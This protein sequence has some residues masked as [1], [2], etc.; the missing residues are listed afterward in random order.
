MLLLSMFGLKH[1]IFTESQQSCSNRCKF[2]EAR[3]WLKSQCFHW[4][5]FSESTTLQKLPSVQNEGPKHIEETNCHL[6]CTL[7]GESSDKVINL[8]KIKK[9]A[10]ITLW[11]VPETLGQPI[12]QMPS[13][14]VALLR[15]KPWGWPCWMGMDF[16]PLF[17]PSFPPKD[18]I[19]GYERRQASWLTG[20][21]LVTRSDQHCHY[22]LSAKSRCRTKSV[23]TDTHIPTAF[24]AWKKKIEIH[25]AAWLRTAGQS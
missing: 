20:G 14:P 13:I 18:R 22:T 17:F 5:T 25:I 4:V 9:R 10:E 19:K 6:S 21:R 16:S 1:V 7:F 15:H 8:P 11:G 23:K 2:A 3:A 24:M 12:T